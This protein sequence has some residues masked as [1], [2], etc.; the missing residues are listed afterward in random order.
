MIQRRYHIRDG[1]KTTAG[2]TVKAS[3]TWYKVDGKPLA[4]EGDSVD[5]PVCGTE[6]VIRCVMPR[7][8]ERLNGREIALSDDLCICLCNPPP[9]LIADQTAKCQFHLSIGAEDR[10]QQ[11]SST[12]AA[13]TEAAVYDERAQLVALPI[14][15]IPYF[16]ET[17]DGQAF[18]GRAGPGGL[19]PRVTT[20]SESVYHVYWGDEA[21]A[22]MVDGQAHE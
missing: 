20:G 14:E 3:N 6:G 2:G 21:L 17:L 10:G 11:M 12:S 15:G 4:C 8:P 22:K 1:A 5:C 9:K 19:L 16:I 7:I 18:H 13:A